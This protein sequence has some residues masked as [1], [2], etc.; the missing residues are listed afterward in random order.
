MQEKASELLEKKSAAHHK[1]E[2]R[3][4][5]PGMILKIKKNAGEIISQGETIII[6]EAMK[7]ENDLR[8]PNSGLIKNI[9][10]K[11]GAAV[12]KGAA[13]FTIE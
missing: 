7:M 3:A 4:P 2:V 6:L 8:A 1:T 12:E 13:L 11:E 10:V 5:M 9:L